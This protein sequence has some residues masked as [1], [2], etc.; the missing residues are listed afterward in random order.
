MSHGFCN[1]RDTTKLCPIQIVVSDVVDQT[2][3]HLQL[4]MSMNNRLTL[5]LK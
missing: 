4:D 1:S 2:D 5:P 3:T